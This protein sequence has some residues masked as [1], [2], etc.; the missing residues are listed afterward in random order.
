MYPLLIEHTLS[1]NY[2]LEIASHYFHV[3]FYKSRLFTKHFANSS[4]TKCKN[5]MY[6]QINVAHSLEKWFSNVVWS[7]NTFTVSNTMHFMFIQVL[8][9][10]RNNCYKICAAKRNYINFNGRHDRLQQFLNRNHLQISFYR[11][12]AVSCSNECV[13]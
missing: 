12:Y 1:S 4:S 6:F 10:R 3:N 5:L 13:K 11:Y 2:S 9:R 8:S 7:G